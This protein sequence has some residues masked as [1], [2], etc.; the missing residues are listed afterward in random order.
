[1][2]VGERHYES[3]AR[4]EAPDRRT[5]SAAN[6]MKKL[7]SSD[8]LPVMFAFGELK[9]AHLSGFMVRNHGK[10]LSIAVD[11][12][13]LDILERTI[14]IERCLFELDRAR[15][16]DEERGLRKLP[17]ADFFPVRRKRIGMDRWKTALAKLTIHISAV[18]KVEQHRNT[19]SLE[20][21]SEANSLVRC[22]NDNTISYLHGLVP[23]NLHEHQ[24]RNLDTEAP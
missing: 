4:V 13:H 21:R 19:P 11:V 23:D 3:V 24:F 14:G 6:R 18:Y 7:V 5:L 20:C 16:I 1:M 10:A 8:V 17:F 15:A 22:V 9:V 2:V 12:K